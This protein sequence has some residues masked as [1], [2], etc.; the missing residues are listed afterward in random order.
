MSLKEE[1]RQLVAG[2]RLTLA[3]TFDPGTR[4]PKDFK[5]LH[6]F[7]KREFPSY[8]VYEAA[9]AVDV[10]ILSFNELPTHRAFLGMLAQAIQLRFGKQTKLVGMSGWENARLII[11]ADYGISS[12]P[13]LSKLFR[14]G[15]RP[16]QT[17]LGKTPL[18]LLTDLA[19]YM[20]EPKLKRSLWKALVDV[21]YQS[22]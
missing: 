18:F 22:S 9:P 20:R 3:E 14:E 6:E 13:A 1:V 19:L 7:H 21:L 2:T 11:A 12:N 8:E 17:F 5:A 4:L 16:G 10:A 15:D